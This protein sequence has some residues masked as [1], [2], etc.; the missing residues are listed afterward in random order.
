MADHDELVRDDAP[1][2]ASKDVHPDRELSAETVTIGKPATELYNHWRDV[3]NLPGFVENL[4]SIE[5]LDERRSRWTVKAP[6]GKT[7][8]WVSR[9]TSS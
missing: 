2:T 7:V 4:E 9:I 1:I 3:G 6:G 5:R 8:S